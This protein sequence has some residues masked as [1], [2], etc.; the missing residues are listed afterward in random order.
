MID[1]EFRVSYEKGK[2]PGAIIETLTIEVLWLLTNFFSLPTQIVNQIIFVKNN[3]SQTSQVF[4]LLNVFLQSE[5]LHLKVMALEAVANAVTNNAE[6]SLA[7]I[8]EEVLIDTIY[9]LC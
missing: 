7:F 8:K 9:N 1:F 5:N 2:R 3:Y 4:N 6:V